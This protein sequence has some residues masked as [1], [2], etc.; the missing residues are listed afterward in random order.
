MKLTTIKIVFTIAL[1][2]HW[3]IY[4]LDINNVF[5]NGV[6][7][8]NVFMKQHHGFIDETYLVCKLHKALYGP[9]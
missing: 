5:L 4:Q 2:R 6:L 9:K 1:I 7:Q 3:C 8:E